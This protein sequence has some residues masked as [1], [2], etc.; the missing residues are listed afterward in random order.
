[1]KRGIVLEDLE[2]QSW[3]ICTFQFVNS[4]ICTQ[5]LAAVSFKI[6]FITLYWWLNSVYLSSAADMCSLPTFMSLWNMG[7]CRNIPWLSFCIMSWSYARCLLHS[8]ILFPQ[9]QKKPPGKLKPLCL[10]LPLVS[11][12]DGPSSLCLKKAPCETFFCCSFSFLYLLGKLLIHLYH[13]YRISGN[14]AFASLPHGIPFLM[15]KLCLLDI[16]HYAGV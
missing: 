15:F 12:K 2:V 7:V 1:M 11:E 13:F 4:I 16:K 6:F 10:E 14:S 5:F 9:T 3:S 8:C